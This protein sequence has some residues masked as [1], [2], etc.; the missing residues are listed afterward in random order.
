ML[1]HSYTSL[2]MSTSCR[3]WISYIWGLMWLSFH[4]SVF[5]TKWS[6]QAINRLEVNKVC[7][8]QTN[9]MY[10]HHTFQ[11]FKYVKLI[12]IGGFKFFS[13]F[14]VCLPYLLHRFH[15]GMV[16]DEF[17]GETH[18]TSF[19]FL[20]IIFVSTIWFLWYNTC[21]YLMPCS[22]DVVHKGGKSLHCKFLALRLLGKM[23]LV[24]DLTLEIP[25]IGLG[26]L[27]C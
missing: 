4:W 5:T 16:W 22:S 23:T 9:S 27:K 19:T 8:S 10:Y 2:C 20:S 3:A 6:E 7:E 1:A 24:G 13:W 25:S 12:N 15:V 21:H 14:R 26:V 11:G 18:A 17:G